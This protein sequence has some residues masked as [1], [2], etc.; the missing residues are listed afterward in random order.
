MARTNQTKRTTKE[1]HWYFYVYATGHGIPSHFIMHVGYSQSNESGGYP[2]WY[3][4][5]MTLDTAHKIHEKV[6]WQDGTEWTGAKAQR[7][8]EEINNYIKMAKEGKL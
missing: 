6:S 2:T 8:K 1:K 3:S 7:L 4:E 5:G